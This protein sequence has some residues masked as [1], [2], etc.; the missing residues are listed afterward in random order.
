MPLVGAETPRFVP[1]PAAQR[2]GPPLPDL[3]GAA[4][5]RH[6]AAWAAATLALGAGVALQWPGSSVVAW[7]ARHG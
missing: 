6:P 2:H 1:L 3:F 4:L 7:L 5:R